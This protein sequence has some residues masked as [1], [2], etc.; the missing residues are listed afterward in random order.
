M[1]SMVH[2]YLKQIDWDIVKIS[3]FLIILFYG[4]NF[5]IEYATD[6]YSTFQ[7]A[8]TWKWMLYEN[9]R[10]INA[11]LYYVIE[12]L[13][14]PNGYVYKLSY[15]LA[16]FCLAIATYILAKLLNKF[17]VNKFL[18]TNKGE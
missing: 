2:K 13:Q 18:C 6:T 7:E 4:V 17:C 3:S 10:L 15:L 11:A 12:K 1:K 9:G 16:I 8:D 14:I 5:S